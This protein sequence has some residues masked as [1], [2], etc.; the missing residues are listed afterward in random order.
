MFLALG[1]V[2]RADD[3]P[4]RDMLTRSARPEDLEMPLSGFADYITP[5][6]RFFVRTHVAVPTVDLASWRLTVEGEVA[7]PRTLTMQDVRGLPSVE[8]V[9]VLECAGNGRRFY[10]PPVPGV[11]W[12]NG[13]VGNGRWRGVRLADVL[14]AAGIK[15]S[16][17]EVLFDGGDVPIGTMPDFVRSIPISKALEANTL[18]AYEMNGEPL[19]AK[20]GFP[21]R[22]VVPGWAGDAW[23]KWVTS[24]RVLDREHDGFWMTRAYRHPGKP[25]AP[26]TPIAPEQMP[27][28][29]SLRVKSVIAG[30]TD[31]EF[32]AAGTPV[33]IRGTAW[34]GDAGPVDAV[35]V[36]VDGGRQWR[37]ARLRREERTRFGWRQWEFNWTP[38]QD[39]YY[40][41][42]ARARDAAGNMQPMD[43]EWN[44]SGYAW[45]VIPRVGV[46]VVRGVPGDRA[47]AGAPPAASVSAIAPPASLRSSCGACHDDDLI[48]QQRLTRAAWDREI[49]KMVG[50]GAK[51]T[52]DD[53]ATLLE[54][55][56]GNFGPRPR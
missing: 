4:K 46:N 41:L 24:I 10:D 52:G 15:G 16:A 51:V 53:R 44:P 32:L 7:S 12:G 9:A 3:R 1:A 48:R 42:L 34:S 40:T 27:P 19:P 14:R 39:A 11:Q 17:R 38:S 30:P 50:W 37:P 8:V 22:V 31:G 33:V 54:Y 45:N 2:L 26:G 23:T 49:D 20:H 43:Q 56:S 25:V 21:L 35:D 36:S 28:V 29:T 47:Q 13:A 55:L 18:L 6:D 5:I